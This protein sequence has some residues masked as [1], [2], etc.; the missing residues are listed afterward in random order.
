MTTRDSLALFAFAQAEESDPN[1]GRSE[2][3]TPRPAEGSL[4]LEDLRK[5]REAAKNL[6]RP[7][8]PCD[9]QRRVG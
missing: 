4:S 7:Q 5:I 1:S 6:P 9:P 3:A 8:E 2:P